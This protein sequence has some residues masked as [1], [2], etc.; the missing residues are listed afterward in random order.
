MPQ[1][2]V[3]DTNI[4]INLIHVDWLSV[5]GAL[6]SYNFIVVDEVLAEITHQEQEAAIA[7]ALS[8]GHISLVR[9]DEVES[10]TLFSELLQ[11]MGRGEA[12][13]LSLAV[14]R[15]YAIACDEKRVFRR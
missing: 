12:A 6:E 14:V 5:L 9:L 11:V 10:L 2:V 15:G 7:A 4:L 13:S 3:T 8:E 1:I